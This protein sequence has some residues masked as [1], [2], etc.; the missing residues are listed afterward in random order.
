MHLLGRNKLTALIGKTTETD[1]WVNSWANEIIRGNWHTLNDL[2]RDFPNAGERNGMIVFPVLGT[3]R[4]IMVMLRFP[5]Q[6]ALIA[7]LDPRD[8]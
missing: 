7:S 4:S 6:V 1:R 5:D 8:I 3:G 2:L